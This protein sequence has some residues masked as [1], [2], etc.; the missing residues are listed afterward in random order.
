MYTIE[1][2]EININNSNKFLI[3][4]KA[5]TNTGAIWYIVDWYAIPMHTHTH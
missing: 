1:S 4:K 2:N 3:R 5:W